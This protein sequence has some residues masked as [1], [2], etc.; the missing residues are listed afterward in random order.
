MNVK[1]WLKTIFLFP[2]M[3][4]FAVPGNDGLDVSAG[5]DDALDADQED[6]LDE[7]YAEDEQDPDAA[8][9]EDEAADADQQG[10]GEQDKSTEKDEEGQAKQGIKQ[11]TLEER[12]SE[13]AEKKVSEALA[14]LNLETQERLE[15]EKKPFV[16]LSPAQVDQL[17]ENYV[18]AVSRRAELEEQIRLGDRSPA[19][20]AELRKAEQWIQKTEAWYADNEKKKAEWEAGKQD[21]QK[22]AAEVQ[23]R[24]QRLET[25]AEVYRESLNIPQDVWDQSS[26]WFAEQL[27]VDKVLSLEFADAYRLKGDIGAVKFAHEYCDK[28]M[29]K[30]EEEA[31]QKR[32]EAKGKLLNTNAGQNRNQ[33][34]DLK[35]LQALHAKAQKSGSEE[36]YATFLSAKKKAGITGSIYTRRK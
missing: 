5:E 17:N 20:I 26:L 22:K 18:E 19:T 11:K 34:A 8:A 25:A 3:L 36:D 23:E 13:I 6:D 31:L 32:Q 10:E 27:K 29:G 33:D 7:E 4:M 12:A 16:E 2:A 14:K 24:T 35:S 28:H 15:S 21:Y 9:G 1:K 30:K